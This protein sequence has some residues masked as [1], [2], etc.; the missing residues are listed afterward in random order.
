[1][2]RIGTKDSHRKLFYSL[3]REKERLER[4]GITPTAKVL[5]D[6]LEESP[7]EIEE[8]EQ[9]LCHGDVSLETP[10]YEEGDPLMDTI[11]SGEDIEERLIEKDTAAMLHKRLGDFKKQLSERECFIFDNRIMTEDPLTLREIGARFNTSRETVRQIQ[12]K[13]SKNLAKNLRSSENPA[14]HVKGAV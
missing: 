6:N 1:V 8:M 14:V 9:R 12:A 10:P 13:I 11:G 3:N 5:A 4:S 2:V 7:A